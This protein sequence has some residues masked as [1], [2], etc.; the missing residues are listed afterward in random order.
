MASAPPSASHAPVARVA[1]AASGGG[2]TSWVTTTSRTTAETAWAQPGVPGSPVARRTS[3]TT[4][5]ASAATAS[6]EVG[7]LEGLPRRPAR[8]EP[9]HEQRREDDEGPGG[10]EDRPEVE[11]VAHADAVPGPQGGE[12]RRPRASGGERAPQ[13]VGQVRGS[14]TPHDSRTRSAGHGRGRALDGPVRHRLR[15][16]DERLDAAERL[17]QR[18]ELACAATSAAARPGG[19]SSP[20]R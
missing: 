11:L 12:T 20:S 7:E 16:L 19:G 6:S 18:E 9:A 1:P 2:S 3:P 8:V 13:V 4:T 15:D 5:T 10:L 14:S 17:G